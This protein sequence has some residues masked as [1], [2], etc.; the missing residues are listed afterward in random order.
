M[1]IKKIATF[2]LLVMSFSLILAGCSQR[3]QPQI[4]DRIVEQPPETTIPIEP[5]EPEVDTDAPPEDFEGVWL[6]TATY[7]NGALQGQ[8]PS[9][10]TLNRNSYTSV[11]SLCG[12]EG[13]IDYLGDNKFTIS[14]QSTNCPKAPQTATYTATYSIDFDEERDVEVMTIVTGPVTET[15]DRQS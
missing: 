8:T 2:V 4:Q 14:Q 12:S 10:F 9:T 5:L 6:R 11:T 7:A 15:Y 13:T 3:P 1:K